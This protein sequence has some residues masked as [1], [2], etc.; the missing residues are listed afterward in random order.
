M[1]A[2]QR[3]LEESLLDAGWRRHTVPRPSAQMLAEIGLSAEVAAV[4]A[5]LG[6]TGF[7]ARIAPG[8]W[9][10]AAEPYILELDE[11][12]HFNRF[13]RATLESSVYAVNRLFDTDEYRRFC[14]DH[15]DDCLRSARHGGYWA[16]PVS[17]REF[18]PSGP[19]GVIDGLGPSRWRQRAFYDFVKDAWALATGLP[20]LRL[21]VWET[22]ADA[23][24]VTLGAL[25]SRL[26]K[27]SD[28]QLT[29]AVVEHVEGRIAMISS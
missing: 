20:M 10:I 28:A 17:D 18:G 27:R 22:V 16:T 21:A 26:V 23:S 13:R 8:G 11:Q 25:L 5:R 1:G 9:D 2:Q 15:E 4:Y 3:V 24:P 12:R 6:G 7:A 19:L 29:Q 14:D